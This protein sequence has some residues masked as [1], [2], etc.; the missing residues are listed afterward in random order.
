MVERYRITHMHMV[1][2]MFVRLLQLTNEQK[3]KYDLSS[4]ESVVHGAAPCPPQVKLDMINWWGPIIHEYY[5]STEAGL[6]T[7]VNSQEWLEKKGT[8]GKPLPGTEVHILNENGDNLEAGEIGD[9]YVN[10]PFSPGFTYHKDSAKR[11]NIEIR[12]LITNGDRGRLTEEGY[13]Y[14]ADRKA[15][16]VISGGVNIYPAE[17]ESLLITMPGLRDCA[18]FGIPDPE[19]GEQLVAAIELMPG[20]KIQ[21]AEVRSFVSNHLAGFKVP[22]IVKFYGKLPREDSGKIFKRLLRENFALH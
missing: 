11:A 10:M 6:I 9:I 1:P 20:I 19:F 2:T 8:V 18:V 14:L 12:G 21:E 22:K 5:G 17:I 7:V 15:D 13:L 16:M 4:L 3:Q